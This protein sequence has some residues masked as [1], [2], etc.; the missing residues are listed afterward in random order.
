MDGPR[1]NRWTRRAFGA[2]MGGLA[3]SLLRIGAPREAEA[4]KHKKPKKPKKPT[5]QCLVSQSRCHGHETECCK[6]LQCAGVSWTPNVVC[7][8]FAACKVN[9]DC[10]GGLSCLNSVCGG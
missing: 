6:G 8:S 10:C 4:R 7:C 3:A 2:V 1:F 5:H 9:N